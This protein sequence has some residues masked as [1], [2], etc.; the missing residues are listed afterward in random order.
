MTETDETGPPTWVLLERA[1]AMEGQ[2]LD[3]T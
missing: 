3:E 2:V 1:L